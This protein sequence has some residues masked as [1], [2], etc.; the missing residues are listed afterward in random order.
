VAAP[1]QSGSAVRAVFANPDLR[2]LQLAWVGSVAADFAYSVAISVYAHGVGGARA[3][4]L[5]WLLR[6]VPSAIAAPFVALLGDRYSAGKVILAGNLALAVLGG[7]TA[8]AVAA[9]TPAA[10]VY[11]LAILVAII[12]TVFWPAQAALLPALARSP[13]E[14]TAANTASIT[15][16]GV[17]SFVG[18]ALCGLLLAATSVEIAIATTG[19]VFLVAVLPAARIHS[20][21]SAP[22]EH[23]LRFGTHDVFSSFT[24]IGRHPGLRTLVGYYGA[25]ALAQGALNVLVV[26][27]AL[28]VLDIG[29][30]GVGLLTA[31]VGVGGLAAAIASFLVSGRR[32]L[33]PYLAAGSIAFGA[34]LCLLALRPGVVVTVLLLA[35]LGAGNL[36]VDVAVLTLLQRTA[37]DEVLIRVLGVVEGLWVAL[38]GVGAIL[39]PALIDLLGVRAALAIAG[40]ILPLSALLA[41]RRLQ[42]VEAATPAAEPL[43]LVRSVPFLASLPAPTL[44]RLAAKL[45]PVRLRVGDEVFR[46]GDLGDR[47]YIVAAGRAMLAVDGR[48]VSTLERGDFFGEI[49]ILRETTRTGTVSAATEL[50][51]YALDRASFL[52][53]VTGSAERAA[54]EAVVD[55]RLGRARPSRPRGLIWTGPR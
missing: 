47:F 24:A 43:E 33:T 45:E 10:V 30:G 4:G 40:A 16:E 51:L 1:A 15:L 6:M 27:L 34:P 49:A 35:A 5:V 25:W 19:A 39:V 2:R 44:E 42:T 11:V 12:T 23:A 22:A 55:E 53:A 9:G 14:L 41:W 36:V 8:L 29:D 52:S 50:E 21:S 48:P 38:F 17:G 31:T 7:A 18:P 32:R 26:V 28:D 46:Q 13:A 20:P 54:A 37:R 3:V